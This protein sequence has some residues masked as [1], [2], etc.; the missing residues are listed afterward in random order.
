MRKDISGKVKSLINP[1]F[2]IEKEN[3][4]AKGFCVGGGRAPPGF[5]SIHLLARTPR[6]FLILVLLFVEDSRFAITTA[7]FTV[8][9]AEDE[10]YNRVLPGSTESGAFSQNTHFIH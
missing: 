8:R 4:G 10:G 6:H 2:A 9:L 1:D 7:D 5:Y 3:S